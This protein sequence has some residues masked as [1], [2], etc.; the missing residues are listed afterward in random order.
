MKKIL[1]MLLIITSQ[2]LFAVNINTDNNGSKLRLVRLDYN[3][4]S[5]EKAVTF[6][7]YSENGLCETALWELADGQRYSINFQF[8]DKNNNMI[9]KVREYSD[10]KNT[11]QVYNYDEKNRI[12][13]EEFFL[14]DTSRGVSTYEYDDN[15]RLAL[16]NC[17]AYNGWLN[18]QIKLIYNDKGQKTGGNFIQKNK[19]V[20]DINYEYDQDGNLIRETWDF[21]KEWRQEF[22]YIYERQYEPGSLTFTSPNP[23]V[24]NLKQP[25]Q[26]EEYKYGNKI[27]GPS[28]Y[29][30]DSNGKL[31]EK[32]YERSDGFKTNTFYIYAN[33]GILL[34]AF[35][36]YSN[37][38]NSLFRFT[39]NDNLRMT[40]K[41][42][43]M[44]DHT[45]G[46]ELYTYNTDNELE[47]AEYNNS[48]LWLNGTINFERPISGNTINAVY[49]DKDGSTAQIN[50]EYDAQFLLQKII[51]QFSDGSEQVYSYLY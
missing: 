29:K 21:G 18:G 17:K 38:K 16:V 34:R 33:N 51:W 43:F 46:S 8:Y 10:H 4:S 45:Y 11:V 49:K 32:T 50:F 37:G 22:S 3:N 39:Y 24:V 36:R 42:F 25:V 19:T 9:K 28:F 44:N 26:R 27:N 13:S 48:D 2:S 20:A 14:R 15:N 41:E 23:Y 40:K 1:F 35:R 6:Y 12:V 5:G 47:K 31:I 30:Y 7:D